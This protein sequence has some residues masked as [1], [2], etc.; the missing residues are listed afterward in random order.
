MNRLLQSPVTVVVFAGL[1]FFITMFAVISTTKL[2]KVAPAAKAPLLAEDDPSWKF[3]NPEIDQWVAQIK[4]ERDALAVREQ[5]LKEWE[6]RLAA[7]SH[8]ISAVTQAVRD[9]KSTRLNSS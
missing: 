4:D 3:H 2:G 1:M 5:Q 6:A 9:R 8:E 7:E